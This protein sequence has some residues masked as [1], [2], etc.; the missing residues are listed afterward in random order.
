MRRGARRPGHA[1]DAALAGRDVDV[2]RL[3][4]TSVLPLGI[5]PEQL[6]PVPR[7]PVSFE[8]RTRSRGSASDASASTELGEP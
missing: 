2:E 1:H 4:R 5:D 8:T 3:A 7:E 6:E